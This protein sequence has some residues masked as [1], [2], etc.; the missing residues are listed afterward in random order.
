MRIEDLHLRPHKDNIHDFTVNSFKRD[1][2]VLL[3]DQKAQKSYVT[4]EI[5]ATP[6]V[7][8]TNRLSGMSP[9]ARRRSIALP[10]IRQ[11]PGRY[12]TDKERIAALHPLCEVFSECWEAAAPAVEAHVGDP[13][14]VWMNEPQRHR[15]L[16][17]YAVSRALLGE[18]WTRQLDL[19]ARHLED[20]TSTPGETERLLADIAT[21]RGSFPDSI[22]I[23]PKTLYDKMRMVN[24]DLWGDLTDTKL[25]KLVRD[26]RNGE[27]RGLEKSQ[28]AGPRQ[29]GRL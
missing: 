18:E 11:R 22:G 25:G 17:L 27:G 19:A 9:D 3:A 6:V 15:W 29:C 24:S 2:V 20:V 14:P 13:M 4:Y 26:I 8:T 21:V 5:G 28:H 7:I 23:L 12:A 1:G 16:L 10:M